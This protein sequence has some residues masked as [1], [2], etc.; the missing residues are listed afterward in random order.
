MKVFNIKSKVYK[1]QTINFGTFALNF[2]EFGKSTIEV[3]EENV[4]AFE[5]IVN[6]FS[7]IKFEEE[8]DEEETTEEV[9]SQNQIDVL[10]AKNKELALENIE[11]K[12][13]ITE[14][15]NKVASLEKSNNSEKDLIQKELNSKNLDELKNIL[16]DVYGSFEEEWNSLK[17]KED[18]VNYILSKN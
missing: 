2:D 4:D 15:E 7:Q 17:K 11:L 1:N 12:K 9:V 14:L 16:N 5:N 18:I 6:T 8:P 10:S 3:E 13:K